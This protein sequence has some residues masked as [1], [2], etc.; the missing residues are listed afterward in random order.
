MINL[1]AHGLRERIQEII[2]KMHLGCRIQ[3]VDCGNGEVDIELTGYSIIIQPACIDETDESV[4]FWILAGL[5]GYKY[6]IDD[7]VRILEKC[8]G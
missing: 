5:M 8:L 1:Q 4:I 6:S 7:L 2:D 3:A